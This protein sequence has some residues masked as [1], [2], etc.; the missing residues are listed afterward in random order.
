M[1]DLCLIVDVSISLAKNYEVSY[2]LNAKKATLG[3]LMSCTAAMT[4]V[5]QEVDVLIDSLDENIEP[6]AVTNAAMQI[7]SLLTCDGE[8]STSSIHISMYHLHKCLILIT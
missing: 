8:Y 4:Q 2:P 3:E 6:R 5:H 1:L 7:S